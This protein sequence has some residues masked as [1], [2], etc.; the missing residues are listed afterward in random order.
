MTHS[1]DER[2]RETAPAFADRQMC[3]PL[4]RCPVVALK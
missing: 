4:P 2:A 1:G 3:S